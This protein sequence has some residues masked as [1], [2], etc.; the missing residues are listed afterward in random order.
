MS[1]SSSAPAVGRIQALASRIKYRFLS[2]VD[3]LGNF[4]GIDEDIKE[5]EVDE[6]IKTEN[7]CPKCGY[8]Y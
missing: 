7:E 2:Q 5:K 3:S 8:K 6:N 4:S 1:P